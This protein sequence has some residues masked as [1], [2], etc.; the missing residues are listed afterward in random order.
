MVEP[1][2]KGRVAPVTKRLQDDDAEIVRRNHERR[3]ADVESNQP[4]MVVGDFLIP[5][6]GQLTIDHRLGREPRQVIF[7]PPRI[8]SGTVG[9]VAGGILYE[10]TSND[11]KRSL[12]LRIGASGYGAAVTVTVS[13]I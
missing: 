9:F 6:G 3:L 7:S 10:V 4:P 11:V 5:D 13:V 2:N 1:V 12:S 8:S